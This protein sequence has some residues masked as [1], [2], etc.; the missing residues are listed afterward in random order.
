MISTHDTVV[1]V[2]TVCGPVSPMTT[3]PVRSGRPWLD[4]HLP[5]GWWAR[6]LA[7][8]ERTGPPG[9]PTAPDA[10]A[11]ARA[12]AWRAAYG[13]DGGAVFAARLA[14]VGLDADGLARLLAEPPDALAERAP[15]PPWARTAERVLAGAGHEV[16]EVPGAW[17]EAFAVPLRPFTD[18]ARE[19]A[20]AAA[21]GAGERVDAPAI[22]GDVEAHLRRRLAGVATKALVAELGRRRD[23]GLLTGDTP[24]ERFADFVRQLARPADLAGFLCAYPVLVRVI[25]QSCDFA[26]AG[27]AELTERFG[28]DRAAI[29]ADLLGGADPGPLVGIDLGKGDPHQRGRAV[30]V[31]RFA[32]GRRVV[33]RPRDVEAHQRFAALVDRVNDLVPDLALRVPAAVA[34]PGYGW[35]EFVDAAPLAHP[36]D[37]DRFYRGLGGLLSLLHIVHAG[38]MHYQNVIAAGDRPV[39]V[40]LETLFHPRF[41]AARA[42]SDPAAEALAESVYRTSLLP[43]MV[44][45]EQGVV[46]CSGLGGDA[47]ELEPDSVLDWAD[48]GTDLMRPVLSP[49]PFRPARNRPTLHGR[50]VEP[51]EH[52]SAVL[53][54]FR[55]GYDALSRHRDKIAAVLRACAETEVRVV[56]RPTRGYV[57]LLDQATDPSA[58]A[59]ALDRER[60]FDV[61][62]T[63]AANDPARWRLCP[64]ETVD[65]WA[66]DVPLFTARPGGVDLRTSTGERVR[67]VLD[68]PG[69]A[70][71]LA[72]LAGLG[73]IDRRDQEWVIS[74]TLATRRPVRP[75]AVPAPMPGPVAG[76]S[77]QAERL[78]VAACVIGDQIIARGVDG[79][80]PVNWLGLELVD[81]RQWLVLPMGVGLANGTTG[82]ALFL[83]QLARLS[84]IDRYADVAARALGGASALIDRFAETPELAAAIGAGGLHGFGGIAYAYARLAALLGDSQLRHRTRTAV[85]LAAASVD[86][87]PGWATGTA[88]CLAAMR[89]VHAELGLPEAAALAARCADGLVGLVADPGRP[90]AGFADGVAGVAWALSR[91]ADTL[92]AYAPAAARAAALVPV[93][94]DAA[95][96]W[97][98]GEAGR[99]LG[100]AGAGGHMLAER[101]RDLAD[102]PVLLGD[103]SLCC[104]ELGVVEAVSALATRVP[105]I[106]DPRRRRAALVLDAIT[107]SGAN[108][109]TPGHVL[110]PGL[111]NGLAG[112][113]YG[114]LRLGFPD[115]T[116]S[117][118]LLEPTDNEVN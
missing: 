118:L 105:G 3:S 40:D 87:T 33:Y 5:P 30:A 90:P 15:C 58:L 116:P 47:G 92:P 73:E 78:L 61:L 56:V 46:D 95:P 14:A 20:A 21:R 66:G 103:L 17:R 84:G 64:A 4:A 67:D 49:R 86:G 32:D 74:A 109:G 96:G 44:V 91:Y 29:V 52:E 39:P 89:A 18:D 104:G 93:D 7:L 57:A 11:L 1:E 38:D 112:I 77:A 55:L 53:T 37:A 88:G 27:C 36:E 12:D 54:G 28:D 41:A 45:G 25:A 31:L 59:D 85:G 8:H 13:P 69:L 80:G 115:R 83:A 82:V 51:S 111:L 97:C 62:W 16:G 71:A 99:L 75:H 68:R 114:L 34:R 76:T 10:A 81:D 42:V 23:A 70:V 113:G 24:A 79:G 107:R 63:S 35:L 94:R 43:V 65:L 48:P 98:R 6:G 22:A 72:K 60:V 100:S 101:V 9:V 19:R 110:T 50:E 108:C 106:A 26:V 2:V 117:A 102:R